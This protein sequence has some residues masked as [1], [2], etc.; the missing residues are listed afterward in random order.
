MR[1]LEGSPSRVQDRPQQEDPAGEA[2]R[3]VPAGEV[4]VPQETLTP[5]ARPEE[6]AALQDAPPTQGRSCRLPAESPPVPLAPRSVE[7]RP[8]LR[9]AGLRDP[10]HLALGVPRAN[11]CGRLAGYDVNLQTR[12]GEHRV[13]HYRPGTR[14]L[15]RALCCGG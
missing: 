9:P 13:S 4:G 7:A 11:T 15:D 10:P 1:R 14:Q 3:Q 6:P 12:V 5:A 8:C 2:G